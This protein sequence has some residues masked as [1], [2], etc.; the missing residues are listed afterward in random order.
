M[1]RM[2]CWRKYRAA[3]RTLASSSGRNSWPRKS[4]RPPTSRTNCKRNDAIG[5]DPEIGVSVALR[6]RLPGD[7]E[8]VPETGI[9]DQAERIDLALQQR[10][11]RDRGAMGE[12]RD[13]I[14]WWRQ[15]RR[16]F[17]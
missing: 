12:A 14:R 16:E 3:S 5:L 4:S 7:L 15:R 11:G 9:D 8:D 1:A 13:I 17:R 10:I 6:H 2:P